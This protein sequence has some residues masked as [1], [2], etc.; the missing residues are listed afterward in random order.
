MSIKYMQWPQRP[1][2]EGGQHV[3]TGPSG[4]KGIHYIGD[5]PSGVEAVCEYH[6]SQI[7]RAHV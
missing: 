1:P 5:Y 7:G 6:R 4:V 3:G 2:N